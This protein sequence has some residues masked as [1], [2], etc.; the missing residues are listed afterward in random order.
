MKKNV[1]M[2]SH[3][4]EYKNVRINDSDEDDEDDSVS[5]YGDDGPYNQKVRQERQ[6][7]DD[8]GRTIVSSRYHEALLKMMVCLP[9]LMNHGTIIMCPM[10]QAAE[11]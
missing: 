2:Y 1:I 5:N 11:Q 9:D 8:K 3:F 6:V 7:K 4:P 10:G